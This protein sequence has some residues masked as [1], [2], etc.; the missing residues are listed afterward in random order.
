VILSL[1]H[2][3][4]PGDRNGAAV[5][6]YL[7]GSP[8]SND[9]SVPPAGR[10]GDLQRPFRDV[11][12][13][14]T[15]LVEE[16]HSAVAGLIVT[17]VRNFLWY[18]RNP[19]F[20]QWRRGVRGLEYS[21]LDAMIGEIKRGLGNPSDPGRGDRSAL[22]ERAGLSRWEEGLKEIKGRIVP[23]CEKAKRLLIAERLFMTN[24]LLS[25][26]ECPDTAISR[27]RHELFGATMSHGG[28]F[29]CLID[30]IDR[31]LYDLI[32]EE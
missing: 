23:F 27:L 25:P 4:T 15:D 20:L 13:G 26:L 28:E 1:V 29:K 24:A 17:G 8:A 30:P 6:R 18:R 3:D 5:L 11:P 31:L 7:W 21:T 12:K 10:E 22:L 16:I 2:F 9:P 19:L 32:R 14:L